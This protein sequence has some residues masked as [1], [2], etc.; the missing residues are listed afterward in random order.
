[1]CIRDSNRT[2]AKIIKEKN[3][4]RNCFFGGI[5]YLF[6][7]Q[8]VFEY[9]RLYCIQIFAACFSIVLCSVY[10]LRMVFLEKPKDG[11]YLPTLSDTLYY[12]RNFDCSWRAAIFYGKLEYIEYMPSVNWIRI[13]G[14]SDRAYLQSTCIEKAKRHHTS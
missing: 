11:T 1:M 4:F 14:L 5:F 8:L 10:S 3:M 2:G 12:S 9:G 6:F 13:F 7:R